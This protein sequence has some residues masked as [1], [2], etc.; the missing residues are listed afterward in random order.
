MKKNKIT[1]F[2]GYGRLTGPAKDGVHT[3][4]VKTADGK[5]EHGEGEE[6][7]AGHRLRR[8]HAARL[9]GRRRPS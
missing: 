4:D 6:G 7:C 1:A 2:K 9:H 8:A 5:T 3:I